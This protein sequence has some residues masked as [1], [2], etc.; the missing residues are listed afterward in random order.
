MCV[1]SVAQPSLVTVPQHTAHYA[2]QHNTTRALQPVSSRNRLILWYSHKSDFDV[3]ILRWI[4]YTLYWPL[5]HWNHF[6]YDLRNYLEVGLIYCSWNAVWKA[7]LAWNSGRVQS[8]AVCLPPPL[9]PA[10]PPL[11]Q[12]VRASRLHRDL[13]HR[14][15]HV[16]LS[17]LESVPC[18]QQ[19]NC[20]EQS[21]H[22]STHTHTCSIMQLSAVRH[23]LVLSV[24]ST[25]TIVNNKCNNS[26]ASTCNQT[27]LITTNYSASVLRTLNSY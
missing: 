17:Q 24:I 2:T 22:L 5:L 8:V 10:L 18:L 11:L 21:S 1:R 15:W 13:Q 3:M 4:L 26:A 23:C 6:I 16:I 19:S 7:F 27:L 14:H 25:W 20:V 12:S 9:V